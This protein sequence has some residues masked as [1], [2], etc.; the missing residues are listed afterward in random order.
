MP[1]TLKRKEKEK[2]DELKQFKEEMFKAIKEVGII[3]ETKK[4]NKEKARVNSK[5]EEERT[6]AIAAIESLLEERGLKAE[7]LGK[8]S[9]YREQINNLDKQ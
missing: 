6:R 4:K 9:N 5:I 7:S 8:Y 3:L 2:S 1:I